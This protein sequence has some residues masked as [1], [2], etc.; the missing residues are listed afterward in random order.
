MLQLPLNRKS[1]NLEKQK[2]LSSL[3]TADKKLTLFHFCIDILSSDLG[4]ELVIPNLVEDKLII[5]I[6]DKDKFA[7]AWGVVKY[8][9]RMDL[10]PEKDPTNLRQIAR[11]CMEWN[12]ITKCAKDYDAKDFKVLTIED[13]IMSVS[14]R[15][16]S[17]PR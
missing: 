13:E 14:E 12:K 2:W 10:N 16:W 5:Q 3:V 6:P 11:N 7:R 15:K 8:F 9:L 4:K 1:S 17:I